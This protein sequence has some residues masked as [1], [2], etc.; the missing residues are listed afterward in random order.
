MVIL[1][2]SIIAAGYYSRQFGF[3]VWLQILIMISVTFVGLFLFSRVASWKLND[4]PK[5]L[6]SYFRV[7]RVLVTA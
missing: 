2:G 1:L 4:I 5:E 7:I 6:R 3:A